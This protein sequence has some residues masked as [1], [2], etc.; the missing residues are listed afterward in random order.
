MHDD[1][2]GSNETR[3]AA[4]AGS[5]ACVAKIRPT[6]LRRLLIQTCVAGMLGAASTLAFAQTETPPNFT[7]AFLGDQGL[8]PHS[9]AVL[10]LIAGEGADAVMHVGDFDYEDDPQAWE[11]QINAILGPD[12]PYFG[13]VGNHDRTLFYEAGG[14]Q[15]ILAARM[16]RLGIVW[17]GDLGV[18]SWHRYAGIS[19]VM[20]AP[21]IFG[22]GDGLHDLYI[23]ERFSTDEAI[24]R[25]S[26]W[27]TNMRKMQVGRKGDEAGWGVY[28]ESRKAGAIVATGHAHLY[29]RSHLLSDMDDQIIAGTENVLA[30]ATDDPATASDEGRTFAFVSGL[31]GRP[32]RDQVRTDPWWASIYTA[33]QGATHGA[34][35][36]VFNYAGDP[37]L[38]YFYFKDHA[39]VVADRFF[40]EAPLPRSTTTTTRPPVPLCG[41]A[42]GDGRVSVTDAQAAL[43]AAVE[44]TTCDA[45][46]CDVDSSGSIST[47]DALL[48][49][50]ASTGLGVSLACTGCGA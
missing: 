46:A 2:A 43:G 37:R 25:I 32:I 16:N 49:L 12:F 3:D 42:T 29:C 38:A 20:T 18:M 44:L 30:L 9:E 4:A 8:G 27:H 33:D 45:C 17:S 36:G 24:W 40:V 31:G 39:G 23:R 19:F 6:A 13:L 22:S 41:D 26:A 10:H 14:Y 47:T 48:I 35:F 21:G 11:E 7:I 1:R 34:L 28:E 50:S 5:S 15:E